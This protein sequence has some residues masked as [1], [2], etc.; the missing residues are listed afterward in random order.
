MQKRYIVQLH[1]KKL[2]EC[3]T[4]SVLAG[5]EG[6]YCSL[7]MHSSTEESHS[8]MLLNEG[9]AKVDFFCGSEMQ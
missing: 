8:M 9:T 6:S 1:L 5:S 3:N 2:T 7:V 4:S